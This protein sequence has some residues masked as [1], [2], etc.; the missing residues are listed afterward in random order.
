[1]TSSHRID[2][3]HSLQNYCRPSVQTQSLPLTNIPSGPHS[4]DTMSDD[5]INQSAPLQ[6]VVVDPFVPDRPTPDRK[7]PPLNLPPRIIRHDTAHAVNAAAVDPVV[8]PAITDSKDCGYRGKQPTEEITKTAR[9]KGRK[10][11]GSTAHELEQH[12][13][14]YKVP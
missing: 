7:N 5:Y 10:T 13:A 12:M 8:R 3:K 11:P 9:H 1:M 14:A 4:I 2:H 6:L